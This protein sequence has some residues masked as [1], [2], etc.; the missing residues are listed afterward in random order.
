MV[1]FLMYFHCCSGLAGVSFPS[2]AFDDDIYII[3]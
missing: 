1:P 3:P 2:V